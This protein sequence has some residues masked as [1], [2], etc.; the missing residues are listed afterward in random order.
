MVIY[1]AGTGN[2]TLEDVQGIMGNATEGLTA[3]IRQYGTYG[4]SKPAIGEEFEYTIC[5]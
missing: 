3:R 5:A 2:S 4:F 1:Y